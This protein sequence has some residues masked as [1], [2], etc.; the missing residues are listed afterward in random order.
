MLG[1]IRAMLQGIIRARTRWVGRLAK[2]KLPT[3]M[4]VGI[5]SAKSP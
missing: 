5:A 1:L 2:T 4:V 3:I